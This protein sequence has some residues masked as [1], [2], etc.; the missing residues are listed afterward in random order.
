MGRG[1]VDPI[2]DFRSTNPAV[3]PA[4]LAALTK[5]FIASGFD[6]RNAIRTICASR[7]YQLE[8]RPN[9]TNVDDEINFAR[10]IP[11]R[12]GAEQLL[13][14]VHL[15]LGGLPKFEGYDKPMRAVRLPGIRA[16][17]RPKRPT[18]GDKF[19][20]LFG[21]PQRLTNSDTERADDTS[22]AQV[23]EL[24][25][26]ATL[27]GLLIDP[28]NGLAGLLKNAG[29]DD[30]LVRDLYWTILTREPNAVER[31]A[32]ASHLTKTD[33]RRA[34]TEDLAWALLNAKEFLLRK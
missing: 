23:F 18:D 26:G 8:A 17:Y 28:K 27:N 5:D 6:L 14:S 29:S 21:K 22:L 1:L 34:A 12:L 9:G 13:D 32:A 2:D 30:E 33:N 11:R 25:S 10:A 4:L 16:V 3:N 7:A 20:H 15:A 24:T 19:L 31:T